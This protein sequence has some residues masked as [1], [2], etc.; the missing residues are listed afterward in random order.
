MTALS[1]D[2]DTPRRRGQ[3]TAVPLAAGATVYA[4][5]LACRNAAGYGTPGATATTLKCVGVWRRGAVNAGAAGAVSAEAERGTYRLDNAAADPITIADIG[6]T[7]YIVD[8]QTVAKTNGTNTRS[9]AGIIRDVDAL[10][11]WVEI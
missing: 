5:G 10:G 2:R 1:A 3:I 9:V 6:A 8:D 11:V 4:G 7:A